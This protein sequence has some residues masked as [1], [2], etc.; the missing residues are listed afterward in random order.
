MADEISSFT[1]YLIPQLN[2]LSICTCMSSL[3]YIPVNV[4]FLFYFF[5]LSYCRVPKIR[6]PTKSIETQ[7]NGDNPFCV[8]ADEDDLGKGHDSLDQGYKSGLRPLS[9]QV[10]SVACGVIKLFYVSWDL[11]CSSAFLGRERHA[12]RTA[13]SQQ[14]C[15]A[16][17]RTCQVLI[18]IF[19]LLLT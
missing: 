17:S 3:I 7:R 16:L 5:G 14:C 10:L 11:F 1:G 2:L 19:C 9:L 6:Y 4:L 13:L 8:Q 12:N 18:N 15:S